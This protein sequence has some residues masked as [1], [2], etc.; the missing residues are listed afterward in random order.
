MSFSSMPAPLDGA[1]LA[2]ICEGDREFEKELIDEYL[3]SVPPLIQQVHDAIAGKDSDQIRRAA[4]TLKG[5]SSSVGAASVYQ[6]S[7]ALE[8]SAREC[9]FDEARK[10]HEQLCAAFRELKEYVP[11]YFSDRAA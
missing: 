8:I 11:V 1:R 2:E 6:T 3:V 10:L 4:H 9:R 5:A 7:L